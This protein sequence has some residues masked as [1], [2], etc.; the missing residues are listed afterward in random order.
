ML[1]VAATLFSCKKDEETCKDLPTLYE[2]LSCFD[3]DVQG[4]TANGEIVA[5]FTDITPADTI[6]N[7]WGIADTNSDGRPAVLCE[8]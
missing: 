2:Q 4:F 5:R 8:K 6:T 1:Q 7:P 3:R